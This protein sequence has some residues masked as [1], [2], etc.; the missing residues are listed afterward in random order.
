MLGQDKFECVAAD[1]VL[2][3][4]T[5]AAFDGAVEVLNLAVR[6]QNESHCG[7]LIKEEPVS[8]LRCSQFL[9]RNFLLSDVLNDPVVILHV[10][11]G[12]P[13]CNRRDGGYQRRA[14]LAAQLQF[15]EDNFSA[16]LNLA[17]V[18]R[19][20]LGMFVEV[21]NAHL[22]E[23]LLAVVTEHA[24]YRGI[25]LNEAP[26]WAAGVPVDADVDV[27]RQRAVLVFALSHGVFGA[28][29]LLLLSTGVDHA[30]DAVE[31]PFVVGETR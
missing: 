12:V 23:F 14:V 1:N 11:V 18:L 9:L 15:L 25:G 21:R 30:L 31:Q 8:P 3:G 24:D 2:P 27:L 4:I 16:S 13:Y 17:V 7:A 29:A 28:P 22:Q 26:L 6:A 20:L 10:A 5:E 19:A